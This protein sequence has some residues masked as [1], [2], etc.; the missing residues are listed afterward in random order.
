MLA[1]SSNDNDHSICI[2]IDNDISMITNHGDN[3]DD[4]H[5][6]DHTHTNTIIAFTLCTH[7]CADHSC[8][9]FT[10]ATG[11]Y[12]RLPAHSGVHCDVSVMPC[13]SC[14]VTPHHVSN[15]VA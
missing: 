11:F 9:L 8:L 12:L 5:D 7:A 2:V 14:R 1:H 10:I 4:N 3:S 13:V 6:N 15:D